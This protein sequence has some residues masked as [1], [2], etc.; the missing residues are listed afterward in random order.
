MPVKNQTVNNKEV[1]LKHIGPFPYDP[2]PE[3]YKWVP[4]DWKIEMIEH[5]TQATSRKC[6]D[7]LFLDKIKGPINKKKGRSQRYDLRAKIISQR[8]YLTEFQRKKEELEN[9]N[10]GAKTTAKT[11]NRK[12][13]Q[14]KTNT[15][16]KVVT[17]SSESEHEM[18][19]SIHMD[20][21]SK[22]DFDYSTNGSEKESI[23]GNSTAIEH[24]LNHEVPDNDIQEVLWKT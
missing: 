23:D 7:K 17:S 2:P 3:G 11:P 18:S 6:F 22:N 16:I 8:K 24:I 13:K 15:N 20:K 19:S 10:K 5:Q 4:N 14:K 1:L 9:I 21:K 12:P